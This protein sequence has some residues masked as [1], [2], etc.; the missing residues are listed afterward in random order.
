MYDVIICGAGPTGILLAAYL[1]RA[2]DVKVGNCHAISKIQVLL[3]E[4]TT[5]IT[6]D[7]RWG[8]S[9]LRLT[10]GEFVWTMKQFACSKGLDCMTKFT[11]KLD[12]PLTGSCSI[13]VDMTCTLLQS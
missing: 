3:I 1:S 13:L 4:K 11:P 12:S 10:L 9:E 8:S 6:T 2:G 5:E 7:P